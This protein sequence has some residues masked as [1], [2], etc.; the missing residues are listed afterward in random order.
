MSFR[1]ISPRGGWRKSVSL[2]F[3]RAF[4]AAGLVMP[5]L[6]SAADAQQPSAASIALA[7]ELLEVKGATTMFDP[8]VPGVIETAKNTFLTTNPGL[9]KD[10]NE[11]SAQLRKE[12]GGRRIGKS[13]V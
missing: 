12:L 10:L 5:F 9:S 1:C 6:Y 13:V 2:G 3:C 7:K 8:V 4:L 11:V